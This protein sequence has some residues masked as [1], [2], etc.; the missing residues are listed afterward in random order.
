M[1]P[2]SPSTQTSPRLNTACF[3][4][5]STQDHQLFELLVSCHL[6]LRAFAARTNQSISIS[7]RWLYQPH[8]A[9]A[10]KVLRDFDMASLEALTL[11]TRL[12]CMPALHTLLARLTTLTQSPDAAAKPVS[13]IT[14]N[15][16]AFIRTLS[17][18]ARLCGYKPTPLFPAPTTTTPPAIRDTTPAPTPSTPTKTR[19]ESTP[20][21]TP[22]PHPKAQPPNPQPNPRPNQDFPSDEEIE[23]ILSE[24][25]PADLI[26]EMKQNGL[27]RDFYRIWKHNEPSETPLPTYA[28][29]TPLQSPLAPAAVANSP[30]QTNRSPPA[31]ASPS[32][33]PQTHSPRSGA[34]AL[35]NRV[36][37]A[38]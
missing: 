28:Q 29:D 13:S 7:L 17:L 34:S 23:R 10:I 8:I 38:K 35:L 2:L 26:Q 37:T 36:G 30:A 1:A 21:P 18:V 25:L 12:R 9:S 14:P 15:D 27:T 20:A 11:S 5:F 32:F 4:D 31:R 24:H 33:P 22:A 16:L 3:E 19:L 6:D